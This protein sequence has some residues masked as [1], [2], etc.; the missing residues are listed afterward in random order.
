V[1]EGARFE[2]AIPLRVCRLSKAMHSFCP[3]QNT[4]LSLSIFR[5]GTISATL[6]QES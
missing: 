3:S 6:N 5:A 1:A 2:L 4:G